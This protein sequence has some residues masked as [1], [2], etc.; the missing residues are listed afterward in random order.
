MTLEVFEIAMS[1]TALL[2]CIAVSAGLYSL[3]IHHGFSMGRMTQ[4]KPAAEPKQYNPG[5]PALGE[6][7]EWDKAVKGTRVDPDIPENIR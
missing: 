3:G 2:S 4:D 6:D 1:V 7:D 5:E